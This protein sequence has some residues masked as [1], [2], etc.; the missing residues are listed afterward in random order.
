MRYEDL[1]ARYEQM[2]KMFGSNA[3]EHVSQLL[4]KQSKK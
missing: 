2:K 4:E 1:K 3:Y